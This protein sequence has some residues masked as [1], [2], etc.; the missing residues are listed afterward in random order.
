MWPTL[1]LMF[2][3]SSAH[4]RRTSHD[5]TGLALIGLDG[6]AGGDKA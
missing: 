4:L 1:E 2:T 6:R 5:A 3:E